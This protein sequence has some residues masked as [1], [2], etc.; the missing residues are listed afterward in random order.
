[1]E[2]RPSGQ[3]GTFVVL[4]GIVLAAFGNLVS[5]LVSATVPPAWVNRALP[6]LGAVALAECVVALL[7]GRI[8]SSLRVEDPRTRS[9]RL[10]SAAVLLVALA[11]LLAA[12]LGAVSNVAAGKLPTQLEPF[13]IPLFVGVTAGV[14]G[15]AVLAFLSQSG[16]PVRETNRANFISHL[17]DRY[18]KLLFNALHDA[19]Q[20]MQGQSQEPKAVVWPALAVGTPNGLWEPVE[21]QLVPVGT[22]ISEVYDQAGGRLLILGVPGAGKT[23]LLLELAFTLLGRARAVR[24]AP[25]PVIFNLSTWAINQASLDVWLAE[26]L[27]FRYQVPRQ[28]ARSWIANQA[29]LPLLDGFDDVADSQRAACA[30]AINTYA[31]AQRQ[32]PIV[33]CSRIAEHRTPPIHLA[34]RLTAVVQP[35]TDEQVSAYLA[36][37]GERLAELRQAVAEDAKLR[38]LLRTPLLLDVVTVTYSDL[39]R[40]SIPP[41]NDPAGWRRLLFR[42]YIARMLERRRGLEQRMPYTPE[43]VETSLSWLA[44]QMRQHGLTDFYLEGLEPTWLADSWARR[45]YQWGV[46]LVVGIIVGGA[47]GLWTFVG[48]GGLLA[49]TYGPL[50]ALPGA[51]IGAVAAAVIGAGLFALSTGERTYTTVVDR[52]GWSWRGMLSGVLW[53]LDVGLI[54]I[55]LYGLY[56]G[57]LQSGVYAAIGLAAIAGPVYIASGGLGRYRVAARDRAYPGEGLRRSLRRGIATGVATVVVTGVVGG[58][59]FGPLGIIAM[60]PVI[61]L[62]VGLSNGGGVVL[63]HVLLLRRLRKAG[64]LPRNLTAF[65]ADAAAHVLLQEVGPG[66][67]YIHGLL[68]DY[69]VEQYLSEQF[70]A[71]LHGAPTHHLMTE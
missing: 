34:L 64:I 42:Q 37:G 1:M 53:T 8:Q 47:W 38:D 16:P 57:R 68:R 15:L 21:V 52:L 2:R 71:I 18:K 36:S 39:P 26:E 5:N 58:V 55:V 13:A 59:I 27:V 63:R 32:L 17:D 33:V 25:V 11:E 44:W 9:R 4:A 45:K 35:L 3:V 31:Q 41:I 60:P 51:L 12:A 66:Y 62:Y 40:W 46:R 43:Q 14:I 56:Y 10:R 67:R 30:A 50:R 22:P 65:L 48:F 19:A 69:F 54:G 24:Q 7:L 29:V 61:G 20:I 28:I 6:A 70:V 49:L 23:T